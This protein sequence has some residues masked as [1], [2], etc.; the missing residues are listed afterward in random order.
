MMHFD[1]RHE[2]LQVQLA[3]MPEGL[4][5]CKALGVVLAVRKLLLVGMKQARPESCPSCDMAVT[6]P[7]LDRGSTVTNRRR[8]PRSSPLVTWPLLDRYSTVTRPLLDRYS[9]QAKAE[10]FPSSVSSFVKGLGD[11]QLP[12]GQRA[13]DGQLSVAELLAAYGLAGAQTTEPPLASQTGAP[14]KDALLEKEFDAQCAISSDAKLW[15]LLPYALGMG[16]AFDGFW[17]AAAPHLAEDTISGNTHTLAHAYHGLLSAVEPHIPKPRNAAPSGS[18][19]AHR[20]FIHVSSLVLLQLRATL[21]ANAT[22][23]RPLKPADVLRAERSQAAM[24]LLIE[25]L[26]QVAGSLTYGDLQAYLPT[27]IVNSTYASEADVFKGIGLEAA[28]PPQPE[29]PARLDRERQAS[30]ASFRES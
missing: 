12:D 10:I 6:R 9:S 30:Q 3:G 26:V 23:D 15:M 7:L 18:K 16:F 11:Q 8:G 21:Q 27:A 19:L 5:H 13:A 20:R 17:G 2:L 25:Q 28:A 24:V 4:S 29:T 14:P 22:A 1:S